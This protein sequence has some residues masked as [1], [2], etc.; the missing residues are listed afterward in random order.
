LLREDVLPLRL[1]QRVR[2]DVASVTFEGDG[3]RVEYV[4]GAITR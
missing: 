1:V 4:E 2:I 3:A